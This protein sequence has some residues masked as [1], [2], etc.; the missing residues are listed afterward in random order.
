MRLSVVRFVTAI[1]VDGIN[2]STIQALAGY[3]IEVTPVGVL[4]RKDGRTTWVP[5]GNVRAGDVLEEQGP[6]VSLE[7]P[8]CDQTFTASA[9]LSSHRRNKHGAAA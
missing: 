5:L 8:D 9:G 7:C 2:N 4:L 3:E 6:T 1:H